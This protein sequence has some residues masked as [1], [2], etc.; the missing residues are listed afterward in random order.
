MHQRTKKGPAEEEPSSLKWSI[1]VEA[2]CTLQQWS[3]LTRLSM[4]SQD[5]LMPRSKLNIH[6]NKI[7]YFSQSWGR[8]SVMIMLIRAFSCMHGLMRMRA[9]I[10]RFIS[11]CKLYKHK[12]PDDN[13]S[14][15]VSFVVK[16]ASYDKYPRNLLYTCSLYITRCYSNL[17]HDN[18]KSP[19]CNRLE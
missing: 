16:V 4:L 2:I 15:F 7:F 1:S 8:I 9:K 3:Y 18:M 14:N 13:T 10:G 11:T 5:T 6:S 12:Q 19:V 17:L